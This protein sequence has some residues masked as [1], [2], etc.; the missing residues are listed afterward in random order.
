MI[1]KPGKIKKY[2]GNRLLD[3]YDGYLQKH[4]KSSKIRLFVNYTYTIS[5]LTKRVIEIAEPVENN[6]FIISSGIL[7]KHFRLPYACTNHSVQGMTIKNKWTIFDANTPYI[8]RNWLWI[9]ITRT[10]KLSNITIFHHN[11]KEINVLSRSKQ[12]LISR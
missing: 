6:K 3:R 9:A 12:K 10:T 11:D 5:K 7:K 1:D 4:Y 8:N 2:L